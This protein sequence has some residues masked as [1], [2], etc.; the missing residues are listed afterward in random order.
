MSLANI[1]TSVYYEVTIPSTQKKTSFRPFRVREEK[2]LLMAQESEQETSMLATLETVVRGCLKS[3]PDVLT[4]FDLEYLFVKI[5]AKSVGEDSV[6]M[7]KC[8]NCGTENRVTVDL[9]EV[10][11]SSTPADKKLILSP[12]L[13]IVMRYPSVDQIANIVNLPPEEQVFASIAAAIETVYYKDEVHHT[14]EESAKDIEEF[15]LNRSDEEILKLVGF[16]ENIPT[17]VLDTEFECR[18]CATVNNLKLKTLS[19]FF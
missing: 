3:A 17:V 16:I 8:S 10:S 2:A 11:L 14:E 19:D 1:D 18:Q 15:L 4:T 12:E 13:A 6:V 9:N 5:R 7:S